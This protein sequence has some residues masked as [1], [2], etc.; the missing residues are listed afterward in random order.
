MPCYNTATVLQYI[1]DEFY[2]ILNC[3]QKK[4]EQHKTIKNQL[5]THNASIEWAYKLYYVLQHRTIIYCP[6]HVYTHNNN[7]L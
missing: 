1:R 6:I 2:I 3:I 4:L 7:T 5:Y